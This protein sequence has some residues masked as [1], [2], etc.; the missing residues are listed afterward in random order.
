MQRPVLSVSGLVL[1]LAASLSAQPL[2]ELF[3]KA[4]AQVKAESWQDALATL[5][6]ID[7]ESAKP[8]N[9]AARRLLEAPMAFYRGVCQANLGQAKEAQAD[10]ERF[11]ALQPDASMD[12]SM[13]SKEAMGAFRAARRNPA[14]GSPDVAGSDKQPAMFRAF[15][16]FKM[17]R[18]A[19]EPLGETWADGPI[20]WIMTEEERR[21]WQ[22][23]VY[24]DE[25]QEFIERFWE[26]RNPRPGNPD[27]SYR[28][29]FERRVAFADANFV[30]A[31]GTR[32]SM[33][34]R[35]MVFVL[36]G[37]PS[38]VGRRPVHAGEDVDVSRGMSMVGSRGQAYAQR[39][40]TAAG[41]A[42]GASG[43]A[44]TEAL[45]GPNVNAPDARP[46]WKEVW[47][48]R[49][50][51]LPKTLR[52]PQ[53]AIEFLSREGRGVAVF[54]R[55]PAAVATLEAARGRFTDP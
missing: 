24:A 44:A 17:P 14:P 43:A 55:D 15:Q 45:F 6:R 5:V 26:A 38:F 39:T 8:G 1:L 33:T 54:Q 37:P 48:Y 13:Y 20:Q 28:N 25:R 9:E 18:N 50:E 46:S 2:P 34:D 12:P 16:E 11:L 53:V 30:I 41:D 32:G 27:N 7:A 22:S 42:S 52:Y 10:F 3:Q 23:L 36:L 19:A 47:H 31:E 40:M 35:G 51:L 49:R 29:A 21:T 4:K